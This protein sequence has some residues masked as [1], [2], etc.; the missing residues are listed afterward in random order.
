[1]S[2]LDNL[3]KQLGSEEEAKKYV[4]LSHNIFCRSSHID[5]C[6]WRSD[7]WNKPTYALKKYINFLETY[8]SNGGNKESLWALAKSPGFV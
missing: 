2:L 1:M 8:L 6:D 5:Q 3:V 4:E 7:S